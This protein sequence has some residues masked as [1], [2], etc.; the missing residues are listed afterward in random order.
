V[1]LSYSGKSSLS[2][3]HR[4]FI[5]KRQGTFLASDSG[6]D[7]AVLAEIAQIAGLNRIILADL[8]NTL[9]QDDYV[10]SLW[11]LWRGRIEFEPENRHV[12][13]VQHS[14]K[15]PRSWWAHRFADAY[16]SSN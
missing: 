15:A 6:G 12:E 9:Y 16:L 2:A 14:E 4:L 7:R 8:A 3:Y 10:R 1:G 13:R 5:N 11:Q